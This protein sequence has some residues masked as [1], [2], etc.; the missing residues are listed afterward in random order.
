VMEDDELVSITADAQDAWEMD[1][2]EFY[3]D[4]AKIGESTVAPYSVRWTIKMSGVPPIPSGGRITAMRPITNP[5]GTLGGKEVV[6]QDVQTETYKK[7][8][9]SSGKR[10]IWVTESGLGGVNDSGVIS[11]TH[12]IYVKAYDRAGNMVESKPVT[13][14][15]GHKKAE[16]KKT[17]W[18]GPEMTDERRKTKDDRP[19]IGDNGTAPTPNEDQPLLALSPPE[20]RPRIASG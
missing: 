2:V 17:G 18:L 3:L 19:P 9:G 16:P 6:V 8:D 10:T 15:V 1:R 14:W 11:E 4:N 13:I 12:R 20:N 5:D 7:P